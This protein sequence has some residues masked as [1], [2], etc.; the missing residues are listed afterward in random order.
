MFSGTTFCS[1]TEGAGIFC[2]VTRCALAVLRVASWA[3][4]HGVIFGS[5]Q[6]LALVHQAQAAI[7]TGVHGACSG[8]RRTSIWPVTAAEIRAERR[9]RNVEITVSACANKSSSCPVARSKNA[10]IASCSA[11]DGGNANAKLPICPSFKEGTAPGFAI[12]SNLTN[13]MAYLTKAGACFVSSTTKPIM[14]LSRQASAGNALTL[15]RKRAAPTFAKTRVS[16]GKMN[17][18]RA[19]AVSLE[20]VFSLSF[21]YPVEDDCPSDLP[22]VDVPIRSGSP[23]SRLLD[24]YVG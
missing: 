16:L 11:L 5:K 4:T 22:P 21:K 18:P 10:A 19:L 3:T 6:A 23:G 14:L 9:S 15:A 8:A 17:A 12:R 1:E 24:G 20:I 2:S 7:R 13:V